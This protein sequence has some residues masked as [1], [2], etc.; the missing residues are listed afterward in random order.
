MA[1]SCVC[2]KGRISMEF[3]LIGM[4]NIWLYMRGPDLD[5]WNLRTWYQ[6]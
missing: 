5:F 4:F 3:D 1:V 6:Q 2:W